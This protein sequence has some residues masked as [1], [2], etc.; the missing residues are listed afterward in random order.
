MIWQIKK[1][2]QSCTQQ[3]FYK[4]KLSDTTISEPWFVSLSKQLVTL[5]H[6]TSQTSCNLQIPNLILTMNLW[7]KDDL[8]SF[9]ITDSCSVEQK[10][11]N[12][13]LQERV[14]SVYING[15]P[16]LT[17][18]SVR[19]NPKE[20][21][22]YAINAGLHYSL[23]AKIT[24]EI[25]EQAERIGSIADDEFAQHNEPTVQQNFSQRLFKL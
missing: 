11:F 22:Q 1:D 21:E 8:K 19:Q 2:L 9:A 15:D 3:W 20:I 16:F 13:L 24:D 17:A 10:R 25:K 14:D 23:V 6:E 7:L 4:D 12:A 18:I 5:K